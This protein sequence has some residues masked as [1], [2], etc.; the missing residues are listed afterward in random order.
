LY[1][2]QE[3]RDCALSGD[4]QG[5]IQLVQRFEDEQPFVE[6]RV[7]DDQPRLVDDLVAVEQEVEVDRPRPPPWAEPEA[8][9]GAL[10]LEQPVEQAAWRELGVDLGRGVQER[11][12]VGVAP[13]L[14][15][16]D[17]REAG[18]A[19]AV[20]R[21]EDRGLAVAEVG[22]EADVRADGR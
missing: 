20:G 14:G 5:R 6:P 7:R 4:F 12:L 2:R 17:R 15:L 3:G 22:A 10:D 13:G 11:R 21:L 8:P 9:E 1:L 18:G 16:A 19:E